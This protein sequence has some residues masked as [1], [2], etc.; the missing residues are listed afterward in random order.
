MARK[1][2][3]TEEVLEGVKMTVEQ[4]KRLPASEIE[5]LLKGAKFMISNFMPVN[6]MNVLYNDKDNRITLLM[7]HEVIPIGQVEEEQIKQILRQRIEGKIDYT[8]I[9]GTSV[10]RDVIDF[11][12]PEHLAM[13]YPEFEMVAKILVSLCLQFASGK[14]DV[15]DR[16]IQQEI[17]EGKRVDAGDAVINRALF[18]L[19][20]FDLLAGAFLTLQAEQ[21]GLLTPAV[22][23]RLL[24]GATKPESEQATNVF[25]QNSE[26]V[27]FTH[28]NIGRS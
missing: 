9:R 16:I 10:P 26:V 21:D 27:G 20:V 23:D 7:N 11:L 25:E 28:R 2:K 19:D 8:G 4:I 14:D 5:E 15:V 17:R 6:Q 18:F 3:T 22:L 24:E 1:P 13:F 12:S